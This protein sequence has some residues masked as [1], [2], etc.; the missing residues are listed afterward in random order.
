MLAV[1]GALPQRQEDWAYEVKWDGMRA[2][3][4]LSAG[5]PLRLRSRSGREV[6]DQYPELA[7]LETLLPDRADA[8]LDGEIV[9]LGENGVPSFG[10]L[11]E[12]MGVSRPSLVAGVAARVPITLMVFDLLWLSGRR[13][14]G[15]P[16][17][18]R[19]EQLRRL[20]LDHPQVRVPP[21]WE[22]TGAGAW[23]WTRATGLEG[24]IAKRL[25][26]PY[27]PGVRSRDWVKVKHVRTV[28][29]VIGGWVPDGPRARACQALLLGWPSGSRSP[30]GPLGGGP[31]QE[32]DADERPPAGAPEQ[33]TGGPPKAADTDGSVPPPSPEVT[34]APPPGGD[35]ALRYVGRVGTGFT[36]RDRHWLADR[37]RPLRQDAPA[38]T[39]NLGG[40]RQ[41]IAERVL[42]VRPE[43][44]CEV[45]YVEVTAGGYLRHPVWRGMRPPPGR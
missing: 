19:R 25:D 39:G 5:A 9:A 21:H 3:A 40:L 28:D 41:D 32:P 14:T 20:G 13:L 1:P 34:G 17:D 22:G 43:L 4:Y 23:E 36:Q 16:Y 18:E 29:V 31:A 6:S 15:R 2:L 42:W 26:S 38:F 12:R 7:V 44:G 35:G 11:Q 37:L 8:I 27:R 30:G 24:L 45:E 10:R 33:P